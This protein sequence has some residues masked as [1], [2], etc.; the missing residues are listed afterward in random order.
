MLP[1]I[2]GHARIFIGSSSEGK[3]AAE[4]TA[5]TLEA[6]GMRP[7]LWSDF[8]KTADPPLQELNRR[9]EE[10]DAAILVAN[11]DDRLV[12]PVPLGRASR[13]DCD[14]GAF[15]SVA[16]IAANTSAVTEIVTIQRLLAL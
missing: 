14:P 9:T 16:S 6:A 11:S 8:F 10:A 4:L 3:P 13:P 2:S 15:G 1:L 7:L 5:A 12:S